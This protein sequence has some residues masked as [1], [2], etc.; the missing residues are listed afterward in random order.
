MEIM[1]DNEKDG[2]SILL[3]DD[4]II[5]KEIFDRD[6]LLP[7]DMPA[8]WDICLLSPRFKRLRTESSKIEWIAS[9]FGTDPALVSRVDS[10]IQVTGAHFCVFNG[11]AAVERTLNQMQ[12]APE[13]YDVDLWYMSEMRCCVWN[14]DLVGTAPLGSNHFDNV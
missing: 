9:P 12:G 1:L 13:W 5:K 14:T 10:D 11:L 2:L 4:V 6:V 8:N 7:R 3:E